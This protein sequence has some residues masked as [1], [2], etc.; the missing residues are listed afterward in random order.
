MF[1]ASNITLNPRFQLITDDWDVVRL[2]DITEHTAV[3]C[4]KH[5]TDLEFDTHGASAFVGIDHTG[6]RYV[7]CSKCGGRGRSIKETWLDSVSEMT[8]KEL[9]NLY[10]KRRVKMITKRFFKLEH[11]L[12]IKKGD[13]S[14]D[15]SDNDDDSDD[16]DVD[17]D[18]SVHSRYSLAHHHE[19]P[20]IYIGI[21][22]MGSGKTTL[23]NRLADVDPIH[24]RK[25]RIK[26]L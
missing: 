7:H 18:A 15:D 4:P 22:P 9:S 24:S 14:D 2:G 10:G 3:F 1:T 13:D 21:S 12:R 23:L 17:D 5:E 20:K 26:Q 6:R 11:L 8:W 16:D 19:G 25:T